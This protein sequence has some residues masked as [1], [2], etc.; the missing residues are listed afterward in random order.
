M[1]ISPAFL[2][3][4][5]TVL[6]DA[7]PVGV[8]LGVLDDPGPAQL[9]LEQADAMLEQGLLVLGVVVLGV[10][11]DVAELA[12]R[13]D[14]LGHLFTLDGGEVVDLVL[15]LLEAFFS[16]DDFLARH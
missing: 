1:R 10:L 13:S 12:R 8:D 4:R 15:Q 5:V 3:R 11:A 16:K 2:S 7:H 6:P 14:A 9:L